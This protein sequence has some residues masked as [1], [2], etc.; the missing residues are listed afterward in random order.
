MKLIAE[1]EAVRGG[2]ILKYEQGD[3][4]NDYYTDELEKQEV[5]VTKTELA[6]RIAQLTPDYRE[7]AD[8]EE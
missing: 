4:G 1:I 8:A 5:F 3:V 2:Y 6:Q 7:V